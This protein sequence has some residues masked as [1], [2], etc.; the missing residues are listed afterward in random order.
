MKDYVDKSMGIVTLI[1]EV[2][3]KIKHTDPLRF[4]KRAA[5]KTRAAL[6]LW[7]YM[8]L[9]WPLSCCISCCI[10]SLSLRA[11]GEGTSPRPKARLCVP[12]W[13]W[14]LPD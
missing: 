4:T 5:R 14:W 12:S 10:S 6:R 8:D 1:V 9:A 3:S 2:L 11:C 13:P 7:S